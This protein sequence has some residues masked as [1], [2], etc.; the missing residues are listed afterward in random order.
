MQKFICLFIALSCAYAC[1]DQIDLEAGKG[2]EKSFYIEGEL[3]KG[4][5]SLVFVTISRVF[6]FTAGSSGVINVRL[7]QL[8]DEVGNVLELENRSLSGLYFEFIDSQTTGFDVV[9]G[10]EYRMRVN[11]LDDQTY[12]SDW[13]T[14]LQAP[15]ML[16]VRVEEKTKTI[17]ANPNLDIYEDRPYFDVVVD[18]YLGDT[19]SD[20]NVR[21]KWSMVQQMYTTFHGGDGNY[22]LRE[23]RDP[24]NLSA[25]P[26]L[27]GRLFGTDAVL[28]NY[29]FHEMPMDSRFAEGYNL[30]I[31]QQA[32]NETAYQ[33]YAQT[34]E[35][36]GFDG[37][38]FSSTPGRITTNFTNITDPDIAA[39]GVFNATAQD[40]FR[41]C[42]SPKDA[43][44]PVPIS[45][46][47]NGADLYDWH[48]RGFLF[49][50]KPANW[51]DC[52]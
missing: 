34:N 19:L 3:I 37:S 15:N 30:T 11:T 43:N 42:I 52:E 44:Y 49:S 45:S 24:V 2:L 48:L 25:I 9:V 32:L 17:L 47:L 36:L 7:V 35:V 18:T 46:V 4:D 22:I 51:I 20:E 14:L 23:I 41:L 8:E 6:D 33:F 21:L 38:L 10:R 27:D 12:E 40:T 5:P 50:E 26:I 13:V 16:D 28:E 1:V 31:Y 39:F 29:P